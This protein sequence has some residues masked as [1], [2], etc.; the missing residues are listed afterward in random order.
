M[1]GSVDEQ[2]WFLGPTKAAEAASSVY[3]GEMCRQQEAEME[4][5][6]LSLMLDRR[7]PPTMDT[8]LPYPGCSDDWGRLPGVVAFNNSLEASH[9]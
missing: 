5:D 9:G 7:M 4:A 2:G 8:G 1:D 3:W 6:H